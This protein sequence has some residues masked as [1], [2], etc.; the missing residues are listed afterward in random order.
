MQ[1]PVVQYLEVPVPGSDQKAQVQLYLPPHYQSSDKK[2]PLLVDVYGG[3][4]FQKVDK[5]WKGH[6]WSLFVSG[7]LDVVY[8][9][10][11]PRGSGYQGDAWRHA[12]FRQFGSVEVSDT[13]S[14]TRYLQQHLPY[15]DSQRTAIWG[16]S[17]GE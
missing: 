6:D 17:Y 3:P 5:S 8:A 11:D 2:L 10:I 16:W 15:V 1:M 14:V 12:V 9:V 13:I 4:G 7:A